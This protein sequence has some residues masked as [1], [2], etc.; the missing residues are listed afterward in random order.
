M[1]RLWN[2][3]EERLPM[4]FPQVFLKIFVG[5]FDSLLRVRAPREILSN[6]RPDAGQEPPRQAAEGR[7]RLRV[8]HE[9]GGLA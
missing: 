9:L 3:G 4:E 1:D 2:L 7:E 6:A 5:D 8:S